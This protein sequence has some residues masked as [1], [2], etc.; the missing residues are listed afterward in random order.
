MQGTYWTDDELLTE[1]KFLLGASRDLRDQT[2]QKSPGF[3]GVMRA[4][5]YRAFKTVEAITILAVSKELSGSM[6]ILMRSLLEDVVSIEY[7]LSRDSD[8]ESR[9]FITYLDIQTYQDL[10][11]LLEYDPDIK[12]KFS[13]E[14]IQKIREDF[15]KAKPIFTSK[16]RKRDVL[17]R[18]W[19]NKMVGGMLRELKD[20]PP[21]GLHKDSLPLMARIY[22]EGNRK[23]HF[24]PSDLVAY[25]SDHQRIVETGM[26]YSECL[27]NTVSLYSR[28]TFRYTVALEIDSGV[29]TYD[30]LTERAIKNMRAIGAVD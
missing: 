7:I 24:N 1:L 23:A 6:F 20:N 11:F 30:D 18:S 28:L 2:E 5:Y 17:H 15:E 21:P 16:Q 27:L 8:F 19:N 26:H 25:L 13:D 10:E 9:I 3:L 14:D 12:Q 22:L 4:T 29:T